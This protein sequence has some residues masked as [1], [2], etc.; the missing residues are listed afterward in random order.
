[1][2]SSVVQATPLACE[3]AIPIGAAVSL[4]GAE[5]RGVVDGLVG[6]KERKAQ[7]RHVRQ[8]ARMVDFTGMRPH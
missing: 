8:I 1:M 2:S 3:A 7:V 4:A 6:R 5:L